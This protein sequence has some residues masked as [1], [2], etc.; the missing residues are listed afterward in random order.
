LP[1]GRRVRMHTCYFG[2]DADL[3]AFGHDYLTATNPYRQRAVT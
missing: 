3:T 2:M 1:D